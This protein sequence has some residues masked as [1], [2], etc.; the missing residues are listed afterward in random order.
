MCV[1]DKVPAAAIK[2]LEVIR[3]H[4][5]FCLVW[6]KRAM[7][8]EVCGPFRSEKQLEPVNAFRS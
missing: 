6:G 1:L 3:E 4:I 5:L 8:S 2:I 7:K